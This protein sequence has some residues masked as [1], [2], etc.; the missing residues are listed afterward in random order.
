MLAN[1][2]LPC[3]SCEVTII[4]ELPPQTRYSSSAIVCRF[5]IMSRVLGYEL[6]DLIHEEI[7]AEALLVLGLD[8]FFHALLRT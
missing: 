5:T 4:Q 1:D 6:A 7:D 3:S 8:V 2:S